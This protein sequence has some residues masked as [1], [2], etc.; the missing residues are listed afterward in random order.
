MMPQD[1]TRAILR[2]QLE[3]STRLLLIAIADHM[4]TERDVAWP[5]VQTL[6]EETGLCE[7]R[8]QSLLDEAEKAGLIRMW[9]GEHRARD[10]AI[11]WSALEG[12]AKRASNRGGRRGAVIA[13][14][15]AVFAP[16]PAKTAPQEDGPDAGVQ[17]LQDGVQSLRGRGA[18]FAYPT[19]KDCTRS[20]QGS[21][22]E[23]DQEATIAP[24]G[25]GVRPLEVVLVLDE[26]P[27]PAELF[28]PEP[29]PPWV[30]PTRE[31]RPFTRP[32]VRALVLR[33]L[34]AITQR[35][36]N[37]ERAKS[38]A[39]PVLAL[40]RGLG[41]P[42]PAEFLAD[43]DLVAR[44]C[45]ESPQRLF[46]N[47]VKGLRA[48]GS[49]WAEDKSRRPTM[50]CRQT[51]PKDS[52]GATWDDRVTAARAWEK[53]GCPTTTLPG[54]GPLPPARGADR[55]VYRPDP[56]EK[57]ISSRGTEADVAAF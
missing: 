42:P 18:V 24:T 57:P 31:C 15:G 10:L 28:P 51:P 27:E 46:R 35:P 56:N 50:V 5:K 43:L 12:V 39:T 38:G 19:G 49:A 3:P 53:L 20:R 9:Q 6:A 37:S 17:T 23:A 16:Q 13:G 47:D 2:S 54:Q 32:E 33:A 1:R 40:W 36:V 45:R 30:P 11:E 14:E 55:G 7:R 22:Q 25:A 41:R 4:S 26:P 29:M 8:V 48:D 34:E 44:A 52:G 21:D